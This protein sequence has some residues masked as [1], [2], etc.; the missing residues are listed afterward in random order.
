MGRLVINRSIRGIS[1]AARYLE[2]A[3][4]N[5]RNGVGVV[6]RN[7]CGGQRVRGSGVKAIDG[8]AVL[9]MVR[10]VIIE[11]QTEVDRQVFVHAPVVLG[12]TGAVVL[13]ISSRR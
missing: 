6:R 11:P 2:T 1:H 8:T 7:G 10:S 13:I 5:L 3:D 9:L 12:E 4:G